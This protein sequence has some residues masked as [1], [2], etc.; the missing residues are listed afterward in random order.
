MFLIS[1]GTRSVR[2]RTCADDNCKWLIN[3]FF[4]INQF[5][6]FK[7][8]W[9]RNRNFSS[10]NSTRLSHA[11]IYTAAFPRSARP[12][13]SKLI[14]LSLELVNTMIIKIYFDRSLLF[15][16][17]RE[18]LVFLNLIRM[19]RVMLVLDEQRRRAMYLHRHDVEYLHFVFVC[20]SLEWWWYIISYYYYYKF[21]FFIKS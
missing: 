21:F 16:Q 19:R 18:M 11:R 13:I 14:K 1:N 12:Y 7:Y 2:K 4:E 15:S 10:P 9:T 20:S 17:S 6:A 3:T 5:R 8:H